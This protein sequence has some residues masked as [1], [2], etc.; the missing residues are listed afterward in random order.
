MNGTVQSDLI[1]EIRSLQYVK[2][3]GVLSR[4][5]VKW[6]LIHDLFVL[7]SRWYVKS[8]L[9]FLNLQADST[10]TSSGTYDSSREL[11]AYLSPSV[12]MLLMNKR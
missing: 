3:R 8:P 12:N 10:W 1:D 6:V 4:E 5:E 2:V 9:S 7:V 11:I